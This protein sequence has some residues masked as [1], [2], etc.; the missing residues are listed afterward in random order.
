MKKSNLLAVSLIMTA[1]LTVPVFAQPELPSPGMTPDSPFYFLDRMFDRFQSPESVADEKA[2]EMLAMAEKKHEK[3]LSIALHSYE[4]AMERRQKEANENEVEAEEVARQA[5]NHLAVL[6]RVREQV[7]EQARKGIDKAINESA[8]NREQ[9]MNTLRERNPERAGVVAEATLTEVMANT[10]E[11]A[12]PGLQT[13]LEAVRR[14]GPPE[15]REEDNESEEE[16]EEGEQRKITPEN[17]TEGRNETTEESA[18]EEGAEAEEEARE[19]A[20]EAGEATDEEDEARENGT[21]AEDA[22]RGNTGN[23]MPF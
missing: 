11:E 5:S 2:A 13:A 22:A 8:R 17:F 19:R 4:R 14:R 16:V 23:G 21:E 6:A 18:R 7:P 12:Q 10:P 9:A 15:Y 1:L 3:G 20:G